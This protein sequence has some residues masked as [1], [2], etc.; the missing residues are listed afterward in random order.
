MKRWDNFCG[1]KHASFQTAGALRHFQPQSRTSNSQTQ[2]GSN[3]PSGSLDQEVHR[4]ARWLPLLLV[5]EVRV[6]A[7]PRLPNSQL[8]WHECHFAKQN[9]LTGPQQLHLCCKSFEVDKIYVIS[10]QYKKKDTVS[11]DVQPCFRS[12]F[13]PQDATNLAHWASNPIYLHH[14]LPLSL[15][16]I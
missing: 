12:V 6:C 1:F 2:I 14:C 3:Y 7:K 5:E 15:C 4:D 11:V 13:L 16:D 9:N 10:H 8:P